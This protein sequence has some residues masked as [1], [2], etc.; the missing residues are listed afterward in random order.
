MVRASEQGQEVAATTG[1]VTLL[2]Q[3][4]KLVRVI[5]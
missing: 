4:K 1:T 5:L 2:S 3:T